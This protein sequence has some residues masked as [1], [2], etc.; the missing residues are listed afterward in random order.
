MACADRLDDIRGQRG[1]PQQWAARIQPNDIEPKPES[2]LGH[3]RPSALT[4]FSHEF[5]LDV[6]RKNDPARLYLPAFPVQELGL[7]DPVPA[8]AKGYSGRFLR[9]VL[10]C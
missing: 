7:P 6:C 1:L 10:P 4:L 5:I 3:Y 9:R 8:G 2:K